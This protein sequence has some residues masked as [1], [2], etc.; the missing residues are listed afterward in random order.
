MHMEN[1]QIQACLTYYISPETTATNS[2]SLFYKPNTVFAVSDKISTSTLLSLDPSATLCRS[3]LH[4]PQ[5]SVKKPQC[6]INPFLPQPAVVQWAA[7]LTSAALSPV[8]LQADW[9]SVALQSLDGQ[10]VL[11]NVMRAASATNKPDGNEGSLPII[12]CQLLEMN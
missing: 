2:F 12:G 10:S 8:Y 6:E 3:A 7:P 9:Y 4:P 1:S 5:G 11:S